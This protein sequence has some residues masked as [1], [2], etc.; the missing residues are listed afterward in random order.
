MLELD[1]DLA[2]RCTG[3]LERDLDLDFDRDRDLGFDGDLERDLDG[4]LDLDFDLDFDRDFDLDLDFDLD[5]DLDDLDRERLA[6]G[7]FDLGDRERVFEREIAP[8]FILM[9]LIIL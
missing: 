8:L 1:R 7:D 6:A 4:D 9:I 3:L 2:L 5:F